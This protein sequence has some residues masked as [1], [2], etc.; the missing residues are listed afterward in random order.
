MK[1]ED[2][3]VLIVDDYQA[4]IGELSTMLA[5]LGFKKIDSADDG[6][7]AIKMLLRQNYDLIISD[8]NMEPITGL[9]LLRAVRSKKNLAK[10]PFL[11]ITT[12]SHAE[13]I[14][15]AKEA[16]ANGCLVKPFDAR[17]LHTKVIDVI[18]G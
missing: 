13:T 6:N 3:S 7:K 16:G 2:A 11:M 12:Q 14:S 4:L 5:Q 18:L 1:V 9:E 15:A 17:S 10:I 8:W